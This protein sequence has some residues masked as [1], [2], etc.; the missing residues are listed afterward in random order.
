VRQ[1]SVQQFFARQIVCLAL[2]T[3]ALALAQEEKV[4]VGLLMINA[5]A[6]VFVAL[7]KGYFREQGLAVELNY[8]ASSGGLQMA[9]LTTGDLDVG[10]GSISP[11]IYNG[12]AGGVNMRVV[13]SK[14]RVGPRASGKYMVRRSLLDAG[15]GLSI[16][17]IKGRVVALNS[18]GGLSRL[19]LDGL[20]KKGGLKETDVVV[21]AM[22]FNDM[23]GA[24]SQGAVDVAFLVQPFIT[25]VDEK[26]IG[27]GIADLWE[28]FPGHMTNNL[29]YSDALIR[30]RPAVGEKFMVGFLKGQRYFYDAV[31]KKKESLDGIV[32][33]VAKYSRVGDRKLLRLGLNVTELTPNGEMD[34]KEIQDDQEWYFQKGLIKTKVDVN[35]MT[36]LR[37]VQSA[38]QILGSYR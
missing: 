6:G 28:L 25:I 11:G 35:K 26:G 18:V 3:P 15:K 4:K 30:N 38:L 17:D 10:T 13:A 31:V 20:L 36:D 37:F 21:R 24:L 16:K 33:I 5:D 23:V 27:V 22:P 19:Y 12:V 29:F 2:L 32:D 7:E 8:F 1:E 14:S 34:L 9:A